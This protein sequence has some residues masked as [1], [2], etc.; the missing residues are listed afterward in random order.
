MKNVKL[1]VKGDILTIEVN[2]K[3]SQGHSASGKSDVI[4]TTSGNVS[5]PKPNEDVKLGLN[6]YRKV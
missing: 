2:L 3:Q 6:L 5:L 1:T 4:A